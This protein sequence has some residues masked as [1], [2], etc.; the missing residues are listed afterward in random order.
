MAFNTSSESKSVYRAQT[1]RN[2]AGS[3]YLN[4]ILNLG[5]MELG[6]GS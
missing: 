1:N 2:S 3:F 4:I 6:K 5:F